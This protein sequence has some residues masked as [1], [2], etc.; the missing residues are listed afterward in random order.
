MTSFISGNTKK[1]FLLTQARIFFEKY[2]NLI[3]KTFLTLSKIIKKNLTFKYSY[4]VLWK[5]LRDHVLQCTKVSVKHETPES[6]RKLAHFEG[7]ASPQQPP[8]ERRRHT[9]INN[10]MGK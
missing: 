5:K 8:N 10:R 1:L 6:R 3:S 4:V 2:F 7:G 9:N